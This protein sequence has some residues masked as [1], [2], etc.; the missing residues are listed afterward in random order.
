MLDLMGSVGATRFYVTWTDID[1]VNKVHYE[2]EVSLA[3][4]ARRLP[5]ILEE[6]TDHRHNVIVRPDGDNRTFTQLDDL[7]ADQLP[8]ILTPTPPVFLILKTSPG[9]DGL[10]NYQAWLAMDGD[11]DKEFTRRLKDRIKAD[12]NATGAT[13]I[14]G[15]LNFKTLYAPEKTGKPWPCV[16]IHMAQP[17]RM[18]TAAELESLGLVAAKKPEPPPLAPAPPGNHPWPSYAICLERAPPRNTRE[19]QD[20]SKA[21]LNF[22]LIS[23]TGGHGVEET[24]QRLASEPESKAHRRGLQFALEIAR[25]AELYVRENQQNKQQQRRHRIG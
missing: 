24:A 3:E 12:V 6:A 25:K 14:A 11:E 23:I 21:D 22:C 8:R 20:T 4:L 17:G 13:R 9:K 5:R 15:S 1:S 7:A 18:T 16:A 10:G 19:G 2:S